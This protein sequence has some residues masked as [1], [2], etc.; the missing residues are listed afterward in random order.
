MVYVDHSTY[1]GAKSIIPDF[2]IPFRRS[3]KKSKAK[4]AEL[5][6]TENKALKTVAVERQ[7]EIKRRI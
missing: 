3:I 5:T 4:L 2:T 6:G 7:K 1:P